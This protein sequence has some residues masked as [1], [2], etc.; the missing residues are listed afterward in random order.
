MSVVT[1]ASPLAEITVK[2]TFI[3]NIP[4]AVEL[5]PA[6]MHFVAHKKSLVGYEKKYSEF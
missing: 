6:I 2:F 1:K 5:Q 4:R 3:R